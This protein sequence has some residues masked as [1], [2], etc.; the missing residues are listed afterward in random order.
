MWI[1]KAESRSITKK[2][3]QQIRKEEKHTIA[4]LVKN[5]GL[6][7]AG[8]KKMAKTV[9]DIVVYSMFI[10]FNA[11]RMGGIN[12]LTKRQREFINKWEAEAF[13]KKVASKIK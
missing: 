11:N 13:R 4:F 12:C 1:D 9:R 6:F 10:R 3:N 8:E 7:V 5:V 2:L